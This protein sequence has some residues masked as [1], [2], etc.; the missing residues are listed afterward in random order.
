MMLMRDFVGMTCVSAKPAAVYSVRYSASVRS[1]P[2]G[3]TT[4]LRSLSLP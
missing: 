3:P 1:Y 2:P 4:M